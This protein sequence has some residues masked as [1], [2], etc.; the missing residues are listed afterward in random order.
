M[1]GEPFT[2]DISIKAN[3]SVTRTDILAL[4]VLAVALWQAG[5]AMAAVVDLIFAARRCS[6]G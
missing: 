3:V 6:S 5:P 4:V 1:S 2:G